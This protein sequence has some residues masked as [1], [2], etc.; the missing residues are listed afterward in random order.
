MQFQINDQVI[1]PVH[2]VA[3]IAGIRNE[4][5]FGGK[6]RLYYQV[7]ANN[8]TVWIPV[9]AQ[10]AIGLRGLTAKRDLPR[11]RRLFKVP[12]TPLNNDHGKRHLELSNRLKQR[13]FQAVC[14]VLRDLT[15][16]SMNK[17]LTGADTALLQKVREDFE[18]EWAAASGKSIDAARAEVETML[19][20][21]RKP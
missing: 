19:Q 8:T 4:E 11:Y 7:V 1:H 10:Q 3:R 18:Q 17:P 9:D 12:P 20:H 14:L 5:F 15:A 21:A 2:G 6:P 16:R 13:S